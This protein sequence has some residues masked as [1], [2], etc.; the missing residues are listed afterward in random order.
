MCPKVMV[1]SSLSI[2]FNG[3]ELCTP[4]IEIINWVKKISNS[5]N[6]DGGGEI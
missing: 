4:K 3:R 1:K 6:I 5:N 2:L